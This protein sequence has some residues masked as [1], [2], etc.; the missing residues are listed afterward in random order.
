MD[1]LR[2]ALSMCIPRTCLPPEP[3]S[4]PTQARPSSA[5]NAPVP[6][7]TTQLVVSPPGASP[8]L[9]GHAPFRRSN[10]APAIAK[11]PPKDGAEDREALLAILGGFAVAALLIRWRSVPPEELMVL[12]LAQAPFIAIAALAGFLLAWIVVRAKPRPLTEHRTHR[13]SGSDAARLRRGSHEAAAASTARPLEVVLPEPATASRPAQLKVDTPRTLAR[14]ASILPLAHSKFDPRTTFSSE[15]LMKL[16][17]TP[18]AARLPNATAT[19]GGEPAPRFSARDVMA[20]AEAAEPSPPLLQTLRRSISNLSPRLLKSLEDRKASELE[21]LVARLPNPNRPSHYA[22]LRE[23]VTSVARCEPPPVSDARQPNSRGTP[24]LVVAGACPSIFAGMQAVMYTA[25]LPPPR[26]PSSTGKPSRQR[27]PSLDAML[28]AAAGSDG[29]AAA[30]TA[31]DAGRGPPA[32]A[33]AAAASASTAAASASAAAASASA[34]ATASRPDGIPAA[35]PAP[36]REPSLDQLLEADDEDDQPTARFMSPAALPS[37]IHAL[38]SAGD[39]KPSAAAPSPPTPPPPTPPPPTPTIDFWWIKP[40]KDDPARLEAGTLPR[41]ET[42]PHKNSPGRSAAVYAPIAALF[43][44]GVGSSS[45]EIQFGLELTAQGVWRA[46]LRPREQEQNCY[47]LLVWQ[48]A[49]TTNPLS[50]T[51]FIQGKLLYQKGP[52]ATEYYA[53][54]YRI[55]DDAIAVHFER[56]ELVGSDVIPTDAFKLGCE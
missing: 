23:L 48:E 45:A 54:P 35:A 20:S 33:A 39:M 17:P 47:L 49:W 22:W 7:T 38:P 27:R 10:S 56:E 19:D 16:M 9:S 24:L 6:A 44:D 26:P 41:Q 42:G 30:A 3:A 43:G 14:R 11:N 53:C 15:N 4:R 32:A 55:D 36:G 46:T 50:R 34:A 25:M 40:R 51:K 13:R 29:R 1:G 2:D 8:R 18:L 21:A 52:T 28:S 5:S 37:A 31:A 12:I